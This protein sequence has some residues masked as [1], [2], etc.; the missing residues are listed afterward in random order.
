LT[1]VIGLGSRAW[2]DSLQ[3]HDGRHFDGQYVGGTE[4]VVAFLTQGSVQYFPVADV[5]LLAFGNGA[6]S[7]M[8]PLGLEGTRVAP[9]SHKS[10]VPW[11]S[12]TVQAPGGTAVR[13]PRLSN[14]NREL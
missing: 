6:G 11:R 10:A 3:L 5:R 2:G 4:S 12:R 1:I 8:S 9:M 13:K 14:V 7:P